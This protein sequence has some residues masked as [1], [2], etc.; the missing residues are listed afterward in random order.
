MSD[1]E[2][3]IYVERIFA[4]KEKAYEAQLKATKES[5]ELASHALATRLET[6]NAFRA[7]I[8]EER[9]IYVRR[10]QLQPIIDRL[11]KLEVWQGNVL[12]RQIVFG[13]AVVALAG[14]IMVIFRF[15]G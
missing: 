6:M 7:Q 5:L 3:R 2:L 8:L 4:E 10:D 9:A 13:A 1:V 14:I 11:D 12:G 15:V